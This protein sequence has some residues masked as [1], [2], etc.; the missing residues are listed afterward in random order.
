MALY[1]ESVVAFSTKSLN[2]FLLNQLNLF[3]TSMLSLGSGNYHLCCGC[4]TRDSACDG[5]TFVQ[6]PARSSTQIQSSGSAVSC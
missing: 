2:N 4:R 3:E 5:A 1:H 6:A